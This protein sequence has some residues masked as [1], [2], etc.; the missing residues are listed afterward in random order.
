MCFVEGG[1]VLTDSF[2]FEVVASGTVLTGV[3]M[4]EELEF[5]NGF[6]KDC[7]IEEAVGEVL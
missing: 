3:G 7:C 2:T 4:V 1:P 6:F 5:C